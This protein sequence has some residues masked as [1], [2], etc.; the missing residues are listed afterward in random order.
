[1]A[2]YNPLTSYEP[3]QLD[4]FDYSETS[5]T[6]FQDEFVDTDTEPSYSC[7]EE[8]DDELIGKALFSHC[9]FKSEKNLRTGDK[10]I[11]PIKKVSRQL[12]PLSHTPIRETRMR[13]KFVSKTE[14]RSRHGKRGNQDS[15]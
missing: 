13:T 10:I 5:A 3:K 11:A 4:N 1:M 14:I 8:L 7:D 15:P 2:T 12:S 9:S 6:V